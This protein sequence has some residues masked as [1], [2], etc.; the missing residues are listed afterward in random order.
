MM[1]NRKNSNPFINGHEITGSIRKYVVWINNT[2]N[3]TLSQGVSLNDK[4]DVE[5]K[6]CWYN[7]MEYL[8]ETRKITYR[9]LLPLRYAI[10][11]AF[12]A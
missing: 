10:D 9:D 7:W 3:K 11:A 5:K 4:I 1:K 12:A 6:E 2:C 8:V